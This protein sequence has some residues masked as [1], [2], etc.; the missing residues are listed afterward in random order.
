MLFSV[1]LEFN[2]EDFALN[3]TKEKDKILSMNWS[4]IWLVVKTGST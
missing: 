2:L 3:S 1:P 4:N